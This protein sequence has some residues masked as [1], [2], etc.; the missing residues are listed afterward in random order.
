VD[1]RQFE[2]L[3]QDKTHP[4]VLGEKVPCG[5]V[6]LHLLAGP[7]PQ[8][9]HKGTL[10]LTNVNLKTQKMHRVSIVN[11]ISNAVHC[12]SLTMKLKTLTVKDQRFENMLKAFTDVEFCDNKGKVD[13][14]LYLLT[15]KSVI[16]STRS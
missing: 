2:K 5:W 7:E 3:Y 8:P 15:V 10:H 14:F 9:H 13:Q 16:F 6:M 4:S 1:P 12:Y 11:L